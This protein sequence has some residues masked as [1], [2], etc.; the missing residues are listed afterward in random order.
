MEKPKIVIAQTH[1]SVLST[2]QDLLEQDA[3]ISGNSPRVDIGYFSNLV[4]A[5]NAAKDA[6][7]LVTGKIFYET[8]CLT[9]EDSRHLRDEYEEATREFGKPHDGGSLAGA[10]RKEN[11]EI[12]TLRFSSVTG[13]TDHFCGDIDKAGSYLPIRNLLTSYPFM[14]ALKAKE[15]GMLPEIDGVDWYAENFPESWK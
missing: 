3:E 8:A 13:P 4:E 14:E 9:S 2:M 5:F 1:P 12:I 10:L 15:R 7:V 6:R 11:P